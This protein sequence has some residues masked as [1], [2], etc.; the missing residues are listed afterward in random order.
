[1]SINIEKASGCLLQI[2][3]TGTA[4]LIIIYA[5]TKLGK[6]VGNWMGDGVFTDTPMRI[7]DKKE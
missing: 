1:M 4:S 3:E 6:F 7:P 5:L 2:L